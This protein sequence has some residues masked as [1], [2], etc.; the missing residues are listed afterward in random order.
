[1]DEKVDRSEDAF[2]NVSLV[3]CGSDSIIIGDVSSFDDMRI[4]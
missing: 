2:W 1:M 3:C 4:G